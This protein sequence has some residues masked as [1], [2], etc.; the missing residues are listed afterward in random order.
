[1]DHVGNSV[2]VILADA[3]P[4]SGERSP[5]KVSKDQRDILDDGDNEA[6]QAAD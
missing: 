6:Q 5:V 1:M 2:L 3:A 4:F